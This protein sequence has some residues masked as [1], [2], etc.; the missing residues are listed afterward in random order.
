MSTTQ[1][2]KYR[3]YCN[4]ESEY[5]FTW[6]NTEPTV[7]PN[8]NSHSINSALTTI[9]ETISTTSFKAEENSD[10]YFQSEHIVLDIPSGI[11]GTIVEKD[12]TW[13]ADI[14]LWRTLITP[15]ADMIGDTISVLAAPETTI[16]VVTSSVNNG[17]V[18]F[19]V[20]STV[21]DNIL[22]GFLVTLFDGVNK[23]VLGRCTAVDKIGGTISVEIPAVNSFAPGSAVKISIYTLRNIYISDTTTIDF[24]NKGFKGKSIPAGLILRVYYTNNSGTSKTLRWRTE[25][26]LIG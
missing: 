15:T 26:Y 17:D 19:N 20:N 12:V 7:C 1:V 2:N 4:H 24:G 13:P 25:S 9:V 23:D 18:T 3:I 8:N 14:L 5:V 16:G 10:G 22:R 11:P 21:T 6:S